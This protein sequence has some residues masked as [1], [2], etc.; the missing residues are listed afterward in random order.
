MCVCVLVAPS[1]LAVE[2][3]H[4][5][6]HGQCNDDFD[7]DEKHSVCVSGLVVCFNTLVIPYGIGSCTVPAIGIPEFCRISQRVNSTLS[8]VSKSHLA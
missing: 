3:D 8:L 1:P 2:F 6:D 7:D 4:S 5:F